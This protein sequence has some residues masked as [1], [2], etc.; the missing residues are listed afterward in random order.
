MNIIPKPNERIVVIGQNGSGKTV[1]LAKMIRAAYGRI[2][3]Y[4]LNTK[5][6]PEFDK[7]HFPKARHVNTFK[8][9]KPRKYAL[10]IYTPTGE[11]LVDRDILDYFL[12]KRFEEGRNITVIDELSQVVNSN[13][14]GRGFVNLIARG[15]SKWVGVWMGSQRPANVTRLPFSE[16]KAFYVFRLND[17]KDRERVSEFTHP[18]LREVMPRKYQFYFYRTEWENEPVLLGPL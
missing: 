8:D 16:S 1:L 15:R 5:D 18:L 13:K 6:D 3:I 7:R 2:P 9:V 4:V 10:T 17:R 14:E 12:Q 11:E